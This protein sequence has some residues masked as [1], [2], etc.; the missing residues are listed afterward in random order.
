[1]Y[2]LASGAT[3]RTSMRAERSLPS[4]MRTIEPRSIAEALIWLGAS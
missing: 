2:G 3:E 1:M 4:G